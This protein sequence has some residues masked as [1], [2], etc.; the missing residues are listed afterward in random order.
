MKSLQTYEVNCVQTREILRCFCVKTLYLSENLCIHCEWKFM[1]E[2]LFSV[3][4][5][6]EGLRWRCI[7]FFLFI[8]VYVALLRE[9]KVKDKILIHKKWTHKT[10]KLLALPAYVWIKCPDLSDGRGISLGV[11]PVAGIL[12]PACSLSGFWSYVKCGDIGMWQSFL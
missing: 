10:W 4:L 2:I 11:P 7:I 8:I 1:E 6:K 12:F 9:R 3:Q 5:Q